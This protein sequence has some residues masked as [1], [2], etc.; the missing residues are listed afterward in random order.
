MVL[1]LF[2]KKVLFCLLLLRPNSAELNS[3]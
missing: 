3:V 1:Q 2:L